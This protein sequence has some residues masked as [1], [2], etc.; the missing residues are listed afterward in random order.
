MKHPDI[1]RYILLL[2][3]TFLITLS[4]AQNETEKTVDLQHMYQQIDEAIKHSAEYTSLREKRI[5]TLREAFCDSMTGQRLMLAEQLF[6][7]YKPYKNDSALHYA[8]LCIS[9][10]EAADMPQTAGRYRSLMARQCSNAGM[11]MESADILRQVDKSKLDRQGL[12]DYYD[13]RMHLCGEVAAYTLI[14]SER[15]YYYAESDHYRDSLMEVVHPATDNYLHMQ[16][17][18]LCARKE[19]QEAL[20]VSDQWLNKVRSETHEEAYAAY[21]RHIVYDRLRNGT[22]TRYW[23]SKSA[24]DDIKCAVMDQA[25]LII[26]AQLLCY[27]G[28]L[29]RSYR[30]IRFTWQSN[31]FFNTRMR[32]SQ[33]SPVLS[34]IERNYQEA[35]NRNTQLLIIS[36]IGGTL[37]TLLLLLL[38]YKVRRQKQRLAIAQADLEKKNEELAASN[39]KLQ[40]MN[41]RMVK[42]NKQLFEINHRLQ[43]ERTL[44]MQ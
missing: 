20:S 34:V 31:N 44:N 28:D 32:A 18:A 21:Y 17:S 30:Y 37:L 19:Y 7:L 16:M 42:N 2:T 43:E 40:W 29:E 36:T 38:F 35:A 12:T 3:S 13:A 33:I 27:D 23:L 4:H 24:L 41:D 25:S 26:L 22:M 10:A 5:A 9:L 39:H 11:Y 1:I 14:P 8:E 15:D 6:W